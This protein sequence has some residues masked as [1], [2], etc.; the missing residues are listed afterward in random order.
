MGTSRVA[1]A[2]MTEDD[3]RVPKRPSVPRKSAKVEFHTKI[4]SEHL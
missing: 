2:E 4:S 1:V 3:G